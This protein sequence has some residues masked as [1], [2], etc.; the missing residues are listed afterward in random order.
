MVI[1]DTTFLLDESM[2]LLK[3]IHEIEALMNNTAEWNR[4]SKVDYC[5]AGVEAFL[6]TSK[7]TNSFD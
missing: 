6:L 1:N 3:Q 4:L 5:F 7:A 2:V